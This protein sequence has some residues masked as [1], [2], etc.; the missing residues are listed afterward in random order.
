MYGKIRFLQNLTPLILLSKALV[1]FYNVNA[2]LMCIDGCKTSSRIG[3]LTKD[4]KLLW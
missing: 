2:L 1:D 4:K 3:Q